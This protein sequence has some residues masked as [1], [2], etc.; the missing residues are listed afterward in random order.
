M[1]PV[2]CEGPAVTSVWIKQCC[3]VAAAVPAA[4]SASG[5][6]AADGC[7]TAPL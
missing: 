2:F 1:L 5:P 6:A 7:G 4:V 3:S